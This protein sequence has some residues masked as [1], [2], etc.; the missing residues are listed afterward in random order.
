LKLIR[1]QGIVCGITLRD[2][3]AS[4][5]LPKGYGLPRFALA[6]ALVLLALVSLAACRR[7]P[8]ATTRSSPELSRLR[9]NLT[10]VPAEARI[11]MA[12]DLDRLRATVLGQRLLSGPAKETALLF[13]GFAKGTGLDLLAQVRQVLVAV[14]GERQ[15]DDRLVLVAETRAL[16]RVRAAAWLRER[17]DSKTA[18]FI[19][20]PD[21]IVIAKG[22]WA[23]EVASLAKP[24][25][26][27]QSAAR[28]EQLRRLCERIAPAHVFWL[29][30]VVP[31]PLRQRLAAE[32]RFPDVASLARLSAALDLEVGLRAEV[33]AELSNAADARGLANRLGAFLNA[34]KHHPDMLAQGLAPYLDAIRLGAQG[35]KVNARLELPA[36]QAEDLVLRAEEFLRKG[37]R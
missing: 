9:A 25:G 11:V 30:A 12:L 14:P 22:A 34:A 7:Q 21:R 8:L 2:F 31:T 29:A 3:A 15:D 17:Q 20:E 28:D 5:Y 23:S 19:L 27:G 13:D 35:P 6:W 32:A 18:A 36:A 37:R 16:D 1:D 10:V 26:P 4:F 33:A 24:T